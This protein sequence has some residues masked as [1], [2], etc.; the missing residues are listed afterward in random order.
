MRRSALSSAF[1]VTAAMAATLATPLYAQAATTVWD[2]VATCESGGN[3]AIS[4]GNGF[5]GG[6]QFTSS[7]WQAFGGGA[8]ASN[9][10]LAS[11][12]AQITIAKRVLASQGPGAWPVCGVKAG[13]N[14]SNGMAGQAAVRVVSEARKPAHSRYAKLAVDGIVG[15]LTRGSMT[16]HRVT[17]SVKPWQRRLGVHVDGKAGSVTVKAMQRWLNAH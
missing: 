5:Y 9:A 13:L 12:D 8:Y 14:R 17:F 6:V 3:W 1:I 2:Q 16:R 7:T 4:T 15:P 10:N 11:K